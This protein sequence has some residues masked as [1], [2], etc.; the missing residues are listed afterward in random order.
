MISI[1]VVDDEKV[2]SDQMTGMLRRWQA[3]HGVELEITCFEDGIEIAEDFRHG[4]SFAYFS[5]GKVSFPF[6]KSRTV[7]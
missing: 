5:A 4:S 7:S 3:A 1:A 6:K 2:F